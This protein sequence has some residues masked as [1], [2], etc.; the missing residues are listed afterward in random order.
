MPEH[1]LHNVTSVREQ[2]TS[3]RE[4]RCHYNQYRLAFGKAFHLP[5]ELEHKAFWAL[6]ALNFE[7]ASAGKNRFFQINELEELRLV[8][9]ENG[10]IFK[11][12]TKIWHDNLIRQKSF[13]VGD[14]QN[15]GGDKFKVNGQMLK[16]YFG[17]HFEQISRSI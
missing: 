6:K 14:Q 4:M 8:A 17:G 10:R 5:V 15:N 9:Y 13:Q 2:V 7:L 12:K 3:L 16:M 1:M 11:E